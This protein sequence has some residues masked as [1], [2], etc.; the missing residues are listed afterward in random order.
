MQA[1]KRI[2]SVVLAVM[3]CLGL[4]A[5]GKDFDAA[6]YTKSVLDANYHGEYKDYAKFRNLSED[7]AK[8]EIE[9]AMDAQIEAAF[10][11]QDVS[12]EAKAKYREAVMGIMKLSK[13]EV[14]G[15]KKD[16]NGNYTVTIEIEPV[17]TFS[18]ANDAF[19]E[20]STQYVTDGKDM[21]NVDVIVD[22]LVEAIN[23]VVTENTYGEKVS[24]ELHVTADEDNVYGIEESEVTELENTMFPGM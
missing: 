17:N 2:L 24:M 22:A 21:T 4:A 23:K 7:E 3:V 6:G 12:D 15:A 1:K 5:C 8:A 14:K 16:D 13:Y 19:T 20:I 9:D 11:G 10:L 18:M